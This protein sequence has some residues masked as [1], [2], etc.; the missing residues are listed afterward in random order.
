M[1]ANDMQQFPLNTRL[2]SNNEIATHELKQCNRHQC[3]TVNGYCS[4]KILTYLLTY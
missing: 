2:I 4:K 3:L 1:I